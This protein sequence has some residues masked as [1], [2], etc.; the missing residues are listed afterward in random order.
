MVCVCM[1]VEI[2]WNVVNLEMSKR[3]TSKI[4]L[5]EERE[6]KE[7]VKCEVKCKRERAKEGNEERK[8]KKKKEGRLLV[9]AWL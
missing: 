2:K 8:K 7:G 9:R 6:G 1:C 3:S 5:R 4:V